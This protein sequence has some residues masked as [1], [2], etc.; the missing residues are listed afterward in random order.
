MV[1]AD[2]VRHHQ[3]ELRLFNLGGEL[4][5]AEDDRDNHHHQVRRE[6]KASEHHETHGGDHGD[7][8][9]AVQRGDVPFFVLPLDAE[10]ADR[11][12]REEAL[13]CGTARIGIRFR[14]QLRAILNKVH[15]CH[16]GARQEGH[17]G[18]GD[19]SHSRMPVLGEEGQ[20][21]RAYAEAQSHEDH[22]KA[23]EALLHFDHRLCEAGRELF[24][25]AGVIPADV[26]PQYRLQVRRLVPEKLP[27]RHRLNAPT[28]DPHS[29]EDDC[30]QA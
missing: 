25:M 21:R 7:L 3:W 4:E 23:L 27:S 1:V 30:S 10:G 8:P 5:G 18:D 16:P 17:C 6:R 14:D 22:R 29:Q 13:G 15:H 20:D 28:R 26:L 19:A 24:G 9:D 2:R 11:A 12:H